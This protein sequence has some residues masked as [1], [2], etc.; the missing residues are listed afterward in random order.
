MS[1]PPSFCL[2]DLPDPEQRQADFLKSTWFK[3]HGQ[4]QAFPSPDHV[5]SFVKPRQG[6]RP[7]IFAELGLVVKF[8]VDVHT[9]EQTPKRQGPRA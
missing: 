4:T 5:H 1:S 9:S 2:A 7:V 8:A 3:T 6:A